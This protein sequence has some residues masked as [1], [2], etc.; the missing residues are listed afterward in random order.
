MKNKYEE[1]PP[2]D[3]LVAGFR[4]QMRYDATSYMRDGVEKVKRVRIEV[5]FGS[6][7]T[8]VLEDNATPKGLPTP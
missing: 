2:S 1:S 3:T 4:M 7:E 6:G 5:E 8:I